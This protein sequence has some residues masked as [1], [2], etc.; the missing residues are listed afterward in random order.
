VER[1]RLFHSDNLHA[2]GSQQFTAVVFVKNV[3]VKAAVLEVAKRASTEV[4]RRARRPVLFQIVAA[5]DFFQVRQIVFLCISLE[6]CDH[7]GYRS[8]PSAMVEGL[9]VVRQD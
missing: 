1:K 5:Q 2:H 8:R 4:F 9:R 3:M 7:M 6:I